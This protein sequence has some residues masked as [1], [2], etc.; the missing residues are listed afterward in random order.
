MMER[1]V[2][3]FGT[4]Y[5]GN[6]VDILKIL[7]RDSVDCV[8]TSPPYWALRDYGHD[9]QIGLEPTF[10]E[11]ISRLC[12]VF[13]EIKPVLK[14]SGTLWVNLGDSYYGSGKGGD[15]GGKTNAGQGRKNM[16]SGFRN[17]E[18]PDRSLCM[19]PQRFAIEMQERGWILRNCIIW[20]KPNCMPSSAKDRFTVD[21]EYLF[22]F[23]KSR[24]YFFETQY[25][26]IKESSI[27]RNLRG[28]N[29]NKYTTGDYFACGGSNTL[30]KPRPYKG[31]G[32][33]A[34]IKANTP[35]R[36]KRCV[37]SINNKP[38]R[39]AHFATYPVELVE[40]PIKAGCPVG[41]TVLDPFFGSGTTGVAAVNLGRKFIGIDVNSDYCE[42]AVKRIERELDQLDFLRDGG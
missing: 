29:P 32:N 17:R 6:N 28:V 22:F 34:E 35:G 42:I 37:W 5:T 11:Y 15:Y 12:S 21:Y 27:K 16:G 2:K 39:E 23:T 36:I 24:K 33:L 40:T 20:H 4:I 31:Y 7:K 26:P 9:S 38:L 14:N 10:T 41:G 30:S 25:E 3:D 13:D 1:K 8:V 18:L 19:V